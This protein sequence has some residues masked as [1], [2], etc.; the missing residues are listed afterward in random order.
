M[1]QAYDYWQDQPGSYRPTTA[2]ATTHRRR[3]RL[4]HRLSRSDAGVR[5][6][7]TDAGTIVP[8]VR[9]LYR[10]FVRSSSASLDRPRDVRPLVAGGSFPCAPRRLLSS[11]RFSRRSST[12]RTVT[13]PTLTF[14]CPNRVEPLTGRGFLEPSFR[15]RSLPRSVYL[16]RATS[17]QPSDGRRCVTFRLV[18]CDGSLLTLRR[19]RRL[20]RDASIRD[21]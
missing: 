21:A 18:P 1:R 6:R 19:R 5:A 15:W 12:Y 2:T 16:G 4:R 17:F 20:R 9:S 14:R 11:P 13:S 3:V 10:S 7:R 8:R